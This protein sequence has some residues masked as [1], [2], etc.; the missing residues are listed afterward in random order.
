MI[1]PVIAAEKYTLVLDL[2]ISPPCNV[3]QGAWVMVYGGQLLCSVSCLQVSATE[4]YTSSSRH[5]I[6]FIRLNCYIL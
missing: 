6:I 3:G 5:G 1:I 4:K 2:I